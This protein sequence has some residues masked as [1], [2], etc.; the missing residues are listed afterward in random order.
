MWTEELNKAAHRW[1]RCCWKELRLQLSLSV[2]T[3]GKEIGRRV[4]T[5]YWYKVSRNLGASAE[6]ILE[7]YEDFVVRLTSRKVHGLCEFRVNFKIPY[8]LELRSKVSI[9]SAGSWCHML[10][11]I[12]YVC[13]QV[14]LLYNLILIPTWQRTPGK[15][16]SKDSGKF[17]MTCDGWSP[18]CLRT[19]KYISGTLDHPILLLPRQLPMRFWGIFHQFFDLVYAR[20]FPFP[21]R[22]WLLCQLMQ[23][24]LVEHKSCWST[25]I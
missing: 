22:S 19:L 2:G 10:S 21:C 11:F 23:F 5:D 20:G 12:W 24:S 7:P 8:F 1:A 18:G 16:R 15:M 17:K 3:W 9:F 4:N 14:T 13:L 6:S 25:A